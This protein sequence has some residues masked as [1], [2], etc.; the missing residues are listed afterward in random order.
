MRRA[1]EVTG[2]H[3]GTET[4][5]TAPSV[6]AAGRWYGR[7]MCGRYH[8]VRDARE[9]L[10][11]GE[12]EVGV[13]RVVTFAPRYNIA[14]SAAA[15]KSDPDRDMPLTRAPIARR[16]A[17]AVA[18]DLGCWP[19]LPAWTHGRVPPYSTA[20]ARAETLAD[21]AT[22]KRAWQAGQR[23][24][25]PATGF[26]EWQARDGVRAKQPWSIGVSDAPGLCF[27]GLW[28]SV[29]GADGDEVLSFTIVTLPANPLMRTL[30]NAGANRH[31]MPLIL[32]EERWLDWLDAPL[33]E[34]EALMTP[35]PAERMNAH[36][37]STR[38]NNP[39]LD[40]PQLLSPVEPAGA[41]PAEPS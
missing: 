33:D 5:S 24:L 3:A 25:V 36:A 11:H 21:K 39:G 9:L 13:E 30:H 10:D 8:L 29:R 16:D 15:P 28:D 2:A 6:R 40:E 27:G 12:I 37:V 7:A 19:L 18:L 32:P 23:C 26:Y 41:A 38:V 34:A 17:N 1:V 35:F 4:E 31:R 22:F 14:P 20:N